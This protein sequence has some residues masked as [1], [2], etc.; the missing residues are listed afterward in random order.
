MN[1]FK[2]SELAK[3]FDIT[4]RSIRFY[5]DLGLLTPERKGNTRIYNGRDRIRL[6]LI[7]RGKRLGF[8]LADIKELFELYDTDQST[9]QL[10][11]MIRLIE[12]KKA[13]LQQQANDIQAVMMELNAAQLRCQNTLRSMK[14]EKVT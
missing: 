10:N 13:A 2:I 5:E 8:S 14:D 3:E 4:T 12:E 11:Y 9:E 1:T 7:L 6:K